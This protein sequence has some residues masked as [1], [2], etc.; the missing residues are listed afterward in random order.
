MRRFAAR[1]QVAIVGYAQS[2]IARHAEQP[3]G[4]PGGRHRARAIADAGLTVDQIDGFVTAS[5]FP[6]SGAHAIDDGVSIVSANWLAERLG[7]N[8][9]TPPA[10]RASARSPGRWPW[11]STRWPAAPPTT[12]WCTGRSTTRPASTTRTR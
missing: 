8:P 1:N 7:V 6:T 11:P 2:Q 9:R 12:C 4:R 10:S 5:L 3:A